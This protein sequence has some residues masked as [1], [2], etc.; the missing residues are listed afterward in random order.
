[1]AFQSGGR[2]CGHDYLGATDNDWTLMGTLAADGGQRYWA[3]GIA[4]PLSFSEVPELQISLRS[5]ALM[6]GDP[7]RISV[8]FI[9]LTADGFTLRVSTWGES[10]IT[11]VGINWMAYDSASAL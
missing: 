9:N 6:E 10:S 3:T 8:G 2:N 11:G 1:M 7:S 5:F 4:F